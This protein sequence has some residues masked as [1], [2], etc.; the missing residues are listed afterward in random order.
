MIGQAALYLATPDD[1][2]VASLTVAGRPVAFRTVLSAVR[3]GARRIGLP[4]ALRGTALEHAVAASPLAR[5]TVIWLDADTLAD[6]PTLLLPATALVPASAL[7]RLLEAGPGAVLAESRDDGAPA[8]VAGAALLAATG[9]A[10]AAGAPLA[11]RLQREVKN[12]SARVVVA[13]AWYVRV[14]G[15]RT[16]AEAEQ[17]L[18]GTLASPIDTAIDRVVHRRLSRPLSR[19]AVAWG[20]TPNQI[21]LASLAVGLAAV[22]CFWSASPASALL[23]LALYVGAVVLDHVDG[24]VARLTL[25]ETATGEWLDVAA[26]TLVH[27]LLVAAMGATAQT[28]AGAGAGLGVL[29]A[30]GVVVS[31][32]VAKAWPGWTRQGGVERVLDGLGARDGF[33]AMLVAFIAVLAVRP[34]LLPGLMLVVAAGANLY[35]VARLGWRLARPAANTARNPK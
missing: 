25:A 16:V 33:Y 31:A 26:D 9:R 3:A 5:R 32:T 19:R 24:E 28:A 10:L 13:G 18:Y 2:A 22:A 21:T 12:G 17:N 1:A 11:D 7:G 14:R 4:A 23:G 15:R 34:A 35:W 29:A 8:M 6:E 27:A 20:R 30:L